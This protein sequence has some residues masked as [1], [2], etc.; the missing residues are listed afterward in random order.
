MV[1]FSRTRYTQKMS[2]TSAAKKAVD[3]RSLT[4]LQFQV[5]RARMQRVR[6]AY[7]RYLSHA[8]FN[9]RLPAVLSKL[10]REQLLALERLL[11]S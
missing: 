6:N 5:K 1:G 4:E 2:N 3:W 9:G 10:T 11:S 7:L 8:L